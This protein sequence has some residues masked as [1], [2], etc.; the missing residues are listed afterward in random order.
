MEVL[1]L[2]RIFSLIALLAF[3]AALGTP[4]LAEDTSS[5]STDTPVSTPAPDNSTPQTSDGVYVVGYTVTDIAGGEITTV[6]VGD[7]VNIVL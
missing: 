5:G 2:K 6:D 1:I 3:V 7:H 4:V